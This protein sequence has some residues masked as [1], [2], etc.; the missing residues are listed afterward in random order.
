MFDFPIFRVLNMLNHQQPVSCDI[1]Q[2]NMIIGYDLM[3]P[4]HPMSP[5]YCIVAAYILISTLMVGFKTT[6][7]YLFVFHV[8][9]S[10]EANQ[11]LDPTSVRKYV[12]LVVWNIFYFPMYWE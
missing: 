7:E 8:S 11:R 3:F 4:L 12:W 5:K 2:K 6:S 1:P 9:M 10:Y